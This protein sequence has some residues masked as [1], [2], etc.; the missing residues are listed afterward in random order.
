MLLASVPLHFVTQCHVQELICDP[1]LCTTDMQ[2][3]QACLSGFGVPVC[4][5]DIFLTSAQQVEAVD[6]MQEGDV[7]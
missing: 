6:V 1:Q 7:S 4:S 3:A 2:Q 5:G